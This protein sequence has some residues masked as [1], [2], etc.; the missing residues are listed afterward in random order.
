MFIKSKIMSLLE[1]SCGYKRERTLRKH[2][3]FVKILTLSNTRAMEE[4][5]SATEM[6]QWFDQ[7]LFSLLD[8]SELTSTQIKHKLPLFGATLVLLPGNHALYSIKMSH[9]VGDGV[10]FFHLVKQVSHCMSGLSVSPIDWDNPAKA[11]HEIYPPSF[12]WRDA[13]VAY[14]APFLV[15]ALK[16]LLSIRRRQAHMFLLNKHKITAERQRLRDQHGSSSISSNDVITAALCKA[17]QSSDVFVFTEN[18]RGV[19]EG[20]P[21]NAA[22]NFFWEVPVSRK[23]CSRPEELRNVISSSNLGYYKTN[24]LPLLP[25]LCGRVGRVTSLASIAENVLYEG[26]E[27][28]STVV[29]VS[30][31]NLIP[32]DVAIIFRFN[33]E[34]WGVLHN[35][36]EFNMTGLLQDAKV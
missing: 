2:H 27:I 16:N 7:D 20:V 19:K 31:M 9:C 12:S 36:A 3:E 29:P 17:N 1:A 30:L 28:M 32:L 13:E 8:E 26:V 6:L 25:F 35:F 10:T 18:A 34:Y 21:R 24:E 22:G 33:A 4:M 14:G 5:A 15:G 11:T 23:V